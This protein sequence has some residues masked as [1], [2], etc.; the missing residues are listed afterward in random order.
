MAVPENRPGPHT[1]PLPGYALLRSLGKRVLRPGGAELTRTMLTALGDLSGL[2]VVE[3]APGTGTTASAIVA[4]GPRSYTGV[5]R[6]A[7]TTSTLERVLRGRGSVRVA[8]AAATGLDAGSADVVVGE[9]MLTMR[10]DTAKDAVVAEVHRVLRAG[11]RYAVHEVALLPDD[12]ADGV[13]QDIR[14]SLARPLKVNARPL[15]VR[16]W[17]ALLSRHGLTVERAETAPMAL[18]EPRRVVADE[19]PLGA[20]RLARN[21][22]SDPAARDR[23]REMRRVFRAHRDSLAAVALIARRTASS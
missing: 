16:E 6:D 4:Q 14:R 9:A 22:I 15:T 10:S 1:G 13:K 21:I 8:D 17:T 23:V 3:I 19:G 7:L 20:A 12:L 18:L 5:E 11:G 2:D